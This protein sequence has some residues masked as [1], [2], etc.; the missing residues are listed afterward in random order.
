[1]KKV[2][3]TGTS[4]YIGS[5]VVR[6]LKDNGCDV[7]ATS[8]VVPHSLAVELGVEV[9]AL[10][11]LQAPI[12]LPVAKG[13]DCL[14]HCATANDILS[15][16]FRA[17]VD[18]S[19]SGTWRMLEFAKANGIPHVI[20][21]STFQVY[22]T[23]LNGMVNEDTPVNCES[24]YGL[25]H[26]FGEESC[27]LFCALHGLSISVVRPSNVYG[28]PTVS[29]VNR[30]T[31]VP[32][33]FVQ[34]ALDTGGITLRSSGRQRRN[35]VST[36]E[37]AVASAHLVENPP[38]GFQIFNICSELHASMKEIAILTG[39]LYEELFKSRLALKTLS[40]LPEQGNQFQAESRLHV[41]QVPKDESWRMMREEIA[42][43][44]SQFQKTTKITKTTI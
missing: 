40:N 27:R 17:G 14:V 23:E 31:L 3:V 37:V 10:D 24:V 21:F 22:G 11:V 8:R 16:D 39:E 13:A 7:V 43:L 1:M 25:N 30:G 15:R 42:T 2:L 28:A 5:R 36:K 34:E 12:E 35:F 4:G 26:W 6:H 29:T 41:L 19:V 18:L 32:M 9:Y 44:F 20:F 38:S 33:C